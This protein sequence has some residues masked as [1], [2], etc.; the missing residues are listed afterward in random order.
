MVAV[1]PSADDISIRASFV[2]R[3]NRELT[4][5]FTPEEDK[6]NGKNRQPRAKDSTR[7]KDCITVE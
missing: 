7:N 5:A 6:H 3:L 4:G 1:G 2:S